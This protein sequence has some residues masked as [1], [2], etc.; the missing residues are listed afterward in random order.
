MA[1]LTGIKLNDPN[2]IL[3]GDGAI[4]FDYGLETEACIGATDGDSK[5]TRKIFEDDMHINGKGKL[6]FKGLTLYQG[7]EV[8]LTFG[9]V[10]ILP[11]NLGK[12]FGGLSS[13]TTTNVGFTTIK[14]GAIKSTDY[15]TNVAFVGQTKG[16][17]DV[18]IIIKDAIGTKDLEMAFK[19][20]DK[21]VTDVEFTA[22]YD[23]ATSNINNYEEPWEIRIATA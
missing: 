1:D 5:F 3:L 22:T 21:V 12:F 18:I 19:E 7:A 15:H 16:G 14:G 6:K 2:N 8:K 17:K 10:E 11:D 13:D 20:G 4:F 9:A 23:P